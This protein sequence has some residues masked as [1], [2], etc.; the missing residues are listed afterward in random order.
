MK[1][2]AHQRR[3]IVC[4]GAIQPFSSIHISPDIGH[5]PTDRPSP[6]ENVQW[7]QFPVMLQLSRSSIEVIQLNALSVFN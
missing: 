4:G 2:V 5:T 3:P 1:R 7:L 6:S